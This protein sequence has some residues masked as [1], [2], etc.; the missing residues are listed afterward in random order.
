MNKSYLSTTPRNA[1]TC[2]LCNK[3]LPNKNGPGIR[4]ID[5]IGWTNLVSKAEQWSKINVPLVDIYYSFT[6]VFSKVSTSQRLS[7]G[8]MSP[9]G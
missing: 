3:T 7:E 8:V 4:N 6:E 2:L 9:A 1:D 5:E